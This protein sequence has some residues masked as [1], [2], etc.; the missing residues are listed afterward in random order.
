MVTTYT[1][2]IKNITTDPHIPTISIANS[3][4]TTT[5]IDLPKISNTIS[6][7]VLQQRFIY[8]VM[9]DG[10][11]SDIH[12][13][14]DNVYENFKTTAYGNPTQM[15]IPKNYMTSLKQIEKN[16]EDV[17]GKGIDFPGLIK[18]SSDQTSGTK[19]MKTKEIFFESGAN[20]QSVCNID[21]HP[22]IYKAE[23]ICTPAA[24]LDSA[25][26]GKCARYFPNKDPLPPP[27]PPLQQS[28]LPPP[29][30]QLQQT[31]QSQT[32]QSQTGQSQPGPSQPG[33]SQPGSSQPEP[34]SSQLPATQIREV[35]FDELFCKRF[36][37]PNGFT[38]SAKNI[39]DKEDEFIVKFTFTCETIKYEITDKVIWNGK[40][41]G[42]PFFVLGNKE[43]NKKINTLMKTPIT[44]EKKKQIFQLLL[45]KELGDVMQVFMYYAYVMIKRYETRPSDTEISQHLCAHIPIEDI[46]MLTVDSVVYLLCRV[47]S[48]PCVYT[49]A[50]A[51]VLSGQAFYKLYTPSPMSNDAVY[52]HITQSLESMYANIQNSNDTNIKHLTNI[53]NGLSEPGR[54]DTGTLKWYFFFIKHSDTTD[55]KPKWF[56]ETMSAFARYTNAIEGYNVSG[57]I[58]SQIIANIETLTNKIKT[59]NTILT[60]EKGDL[61]KEYEQGKNSLL[62]TDYNPYWPNWDTSIDHDKIIK[63]RNFINEKL[64][65]IGTL[66][67]YRSVEHV[68]ELKKKSYIVNCA[69]QILCDGLQDYRV[70]PKQILINAESIIDIKQEV[71]NKL[72]LVVDAIRRKFG[73]QASGLNRNAGMTNN[74]Q[75]I[76]G[77]PPP[78][79]VAVNSKVT[80][81]DLF[82]SP[83]S[84]SGPSGSISRGSPINPTDIGST[85]Q[86][87]TRNNSNVATP[88]TTSRGVSRGS[89]VDS[90]V[91]YSTQTTTDFS[92]SLAPVVEDDDMVVEDDAMFVAAPVVAAPVVEDDAMVV[93]TPG[94]SS[95]PSVDDNS[96]EFLDLYNINKNIDFLSKFLNDMIDIHDVIEFT[97]TLNEFID[98]AD[99]AVIP[100]FSDI[101]EAIR[102]ILITKY[103]YSNNKEDYNTL[104]EILTGLGEFK[105]TDIS[106]DPALTNAC[107]KYIEATKAKFVNIEDIL[108]ININD[109]TYDWGT[110]SSSSSL[111][112]S[113]LQSSARRKGKAVTRKKNNRNKKN[114]QSNKKKRVKNKRSR[115]ITQRNKIKYNNTNAK[116]RSLRRAKRRNS[117][118]QTAKNHKQNIVLTNLSN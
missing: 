108:Y 104:F 105:I 36:G 112:P 39:D 43:K 52:S 93:V 91:E 106:K 34:G 76:V 89:T 109:D 51:G 63:Q 98:P 29:P 2:S 90:E 23:R 88:L 38:W 111:T 20:E 10:N 79:H 8:D 66:N 3:S 28:G 33:P 25:S 31:V 62:D 69:N 77:H 32:G 50:R 58:I 27:P 44:D 75:E 113:P 6:K 57:E 59:N 24:A 37:F 15:L 97:S 60:G 56:E 12:I 82:A 41:N 117:K 96:L 48:L 49:G 46:A 72:G 16:M 80:K 68:T 115:K 74:D 71:D 81:M 30:P 26:K 84:P 1:F 118:I 110:S 5:T 55:T 64:A 22:G 42:K 54:G 47:L 70:R 100:V 7:E 65:A 101:Q 17:I 92:Q 87:S 21:T 78:T 61:A 86:A 19:I 18:N 99:L 102:A 95:D 13:E 40:Y 11:A 73:V 85:S 45:M 107:T 53:K 4:T 114:K 94:Q 67:Q 14:S 83:G 116:Q 103:Y 35:V 9:K